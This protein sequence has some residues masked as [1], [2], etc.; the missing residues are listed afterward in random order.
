M[1]FNSLLSVTL[2]LVL[3]AGLGTPVYAGQMVETQAESFFVPSNCASVTFNF[4][5]MA[6]A[7]QSS[8][9][10]FDVSEVA[11]DPSVDR[12]G[13]VNTAL[14]APSAT[15]IFHDGN[16]DNPGASIVI[17]LTPG[18]EIAFWLI[19][20]ESLTFFQANPN[21]YILNGGTLADPLF[22]VPPANPV[23]FDNL[24][25]FI[26]GGIT[27]F[28][29]EDLAG[30]GDQ[31]FDDIV[32]NVE[33][34]LFEESEPVGGEFLP[35]DSTALLL[36]VASTPAAWLSSLALVAL[37]IGAYVFTRNPNNMRNI[38]VILRDYLDRI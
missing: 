7:F 1:K 11:I 37:G 12:L 35:I 30:G 17:A 22:S 38:K 26:G 2:A 16:P 36:A 28:E 23:G 3:V 18:S 6:G 4:V 32:F 14:N 5:S 29:W 8:F 9:G 25:S 33:C 27:T 15:Q 31:D 24:K 34:E 19:P 20:N 10:F 13:Y 21:S